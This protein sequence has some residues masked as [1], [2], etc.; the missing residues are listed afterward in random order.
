MRKTLVLLAA[1]AL[2]TAACK[3]ET[4]F[5]AVINPDGSGTV[6]AELGFD[7]EAAELLLSGEDPFEG[8]DL[9]A[10]PGA[11]TSEER[12]GDMTYYIIE[13]PFD[14]V[15]QLQDALV[16]N[17]NA[18]LSGFDV[19][20]TE[21]RVTVSGTASG[22][23]LS[24]QAE[25]FDPAV[26]EESVSANIHITLPGRILSHNA[27]QVD[28]NK[29]TWAVP[30]FGGDLNIQAESD[31]TQEP[32]G[33]GGGF[34]IWVIALIVV[35]ALAAIAWFVLRGRSGTPAAPAAPAPPAEGQAPPPPPAGE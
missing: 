16:Q 4:N 10:L 26:F 22:D 11:E 7:D 5:G 9:S 6:I 25:G 19:T 3:I 35:V 20:V 15:S 29:L 8:N 34:P 12:R 28:G 23:E 18:L 14:D 1:V 31:P 32:A 33:D 2:L 13:A 21:D 30:L 27:D 24:S 17:D